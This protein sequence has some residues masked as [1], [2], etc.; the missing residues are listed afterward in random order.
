M[1]DAGDCGRGC[2]ARPPTAS[3]SPRTTPGLSV[4]EADGRISRG[5]R[6]VFVNGMGQSVLPYGDIHTALGALPALVHPNPRDIAIIGLGS[7]DT[8]YAAASRR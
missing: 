1:P 6:V 3:S 5:P 8:V 2:M 7:G 4:I